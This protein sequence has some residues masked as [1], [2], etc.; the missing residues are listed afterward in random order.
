[1]QTQNPACI[2]LPTA[3]YFLQN[4]LMKLKSSWKLQSLFISY[5]TREKDL[6]GTKRD[7]NPL[8]DQV[9]LNSS[10][11]KAFITDPQEANSHLLQIFT[12]PK[13]NPI[14]Y[15]IRHQT[16][17]CRSVSAAGRDTSRPDWGHGLCPGGCWLSQMTNCYCDAT[18]LWHWAYKAAG[19]ITAC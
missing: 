3:N 12:L 18:A 6:I 8:T 16:R 11:A 7:M 19:I 1:M 4:A 14:A 2:F 13:T 15:A 9:F 5:L 17:V 10:L